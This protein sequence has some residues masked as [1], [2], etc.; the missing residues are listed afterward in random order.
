MANIGLEVGEI[1]QIW[2]VEVLRSDWKWASR[3]DHSNTNWMRRKQR[4]KN[5]WRYKEMVNILSSQTEL[6][7]NYTVLFTRW[8]TAILSDRPNKGYWFGPTMSRELLK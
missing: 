1:R 3:S 2:N 6:V 8:K 5:D 7:T 4:A